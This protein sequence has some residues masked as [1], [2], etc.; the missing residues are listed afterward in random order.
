[1]RSAGELESG[2]VD[3]SEDSQL[4]PPD[5]QP[6]PISP[7]ARQATREDYNPFADGTEAE[8]EETPRKKRY[9]QPK[10]NYNPFDE[11]H[12]SQSGGATENPEEIFDFGAPEPGDAPPPTGDFDFGT[13]D[14]GSQEG[15][16]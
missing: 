7:A 8:E 13:G 14:G 3:V 12:S 11:V 9:W 15:R 6:L 2:L 16:R 10:D 5:E 1:V 4:N